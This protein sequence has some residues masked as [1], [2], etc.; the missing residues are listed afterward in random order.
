MPLRIY[1]L[2]PGEHA[3]YTLRPVGAAGLPR[4][5]LR[6]ERPDEGASV[7]LEVVLCDPEG[8]EHSNGRVPLERGYMAVVREVRRQFELTGLWPREAEFDLVRLEDEPGYAA[9]EGG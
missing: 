5:D 2:L 6:V 7:E 1:R 4:L 9:G 3:L 8:A